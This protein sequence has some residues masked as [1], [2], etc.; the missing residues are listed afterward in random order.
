MP[1]SIPLPIFLALL[2]APEA[3]FARLLLLGQS[4]GMSITSLALALTAFNFVIWAIWMTFIYPFVFSPL[5]GLPEPKGALPVLAHGFLAFKRPPGAELLKWIKEIPN[6]GLIRFRGFFNIDKLLPTDPRTLADVLVNNS[7]D[8]QKSTRTKGFLRRV[9][10]DGLIILEGDEHMFQR[11]N[12]MPS[13]SF[14]HIKNLYPVFWQKSL[15]LTEAISTKDFDHFENNSGERPPAVIEV[16]HWATKVTL[17]VIGLAGLGRDFHTLDN[18]DDPL[19]KLYEDFFIPTKGRMVLF[20]MHVVGLGRLSRT[21]L[22]KVDERLQELTSRL[23]EICRSLVTDKRRSLKA[24][25]QETKDILS[26]MLNSNVF[27][28]DMLVDQLLTFLAAGHETT[29]SA[30]TWATYLLATNETIQAKLRQEVRNYLSAEL[31]DASKTEDLADKL[32]SMP[33]LN[34]IC[35][36]VLRLYPTVPVT[37]RDAIR[38]TTIGGQHVPKGTQ[39]LI[40]PWAINRSPSLW[41]SD[42]ESFRPERWID[43][44]GHANNHGGAPSNYCQLTFLHG[45]RSCIGQKFARAELRALIAA[46]V[47]KF[48]WNLAMDQSE[49]ILTG[50]VTIKPK[51]GMKLRVTKLE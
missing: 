38:N 21:L 7:Y 25:D 14:R 32:E 19:A 2:S 28:D 29:S 33:Y 46:F 18:F 50:V 40:A 5:R 30:F 51:N 9:L 45:P 20:A 17:D 31:S 44:D 49:V 15:A 13:F 35:N 11:K 23:R 27:G 42:A 48:K 43:P 22:W 8:F 4:S 16:H 39:V 6:D 3:L 24:Q 1:I 41:G 34:A 36:E 26:V 47:G 12:I 10:G 37:A